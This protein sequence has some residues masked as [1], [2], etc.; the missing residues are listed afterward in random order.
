MRCFLVLLISLLFFSGCTTTPAVPPPEQTA[1]EYREIQDNITRKQT[2]LAVTG[3]AIEQESKGIVQDIANLQ[4]TLTAVTPENWEEEKQYLSVQ[5]SNLQS[6]AIAQQER[7]ETLNKQLAGEREENGKLNRKFNE[8]EFAH[9]QAISDKDKEITRLEVENKAVKGQRNTLLAII[10]AIA[11]LFI[12][13]VTVKVLRF[14][15]V[16]PF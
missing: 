1:A 12:T 2:D 11:I 14:F 10:I 7:A 6:R 15:K 8:Y 3:T 16:L 9:N 4:T 13:M 5:V